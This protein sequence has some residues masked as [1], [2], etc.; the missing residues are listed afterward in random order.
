MSLTL[1]LGALSCICPKI[2]FLSAETLGQITIWQ[3]ISL[4]MNRSMKRC[5]LNPLFSEASLLFDIKGIITAVEIHG[6]T[7]MSHVGRQL[8]VMVPYKLTP[9]PPARPRR[10]HIH[11]HRIY[12]NSVSSQCAR[13]KSSTVRKPEFHPRKF[14]DIFFLKKK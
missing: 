11:R 3:F 9:P 7:R 10:T 1:R 5:L 14:N 12:L 4:L 8:I 6:G 13:A 2:A